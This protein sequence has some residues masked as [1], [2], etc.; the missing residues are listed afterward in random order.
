MYALCVCVCVCVSVRVLVRF[1]R[2][3]ADRTGPDQCTRSV[4]CWLV[5]SLKVVG[6]ILGMF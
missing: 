1:G 5:A 4:A 3:H 2:G 6:R